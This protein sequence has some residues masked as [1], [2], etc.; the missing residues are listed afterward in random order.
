MNSQVCVRK[1]IWECH[2]PVPRDALCQRIVLKTSGGVCK[3]SLCSLGG[4]TP[5]RGGASPPGGAPGG[6]APPP[7]QEEGHLLEEMS[8]LLQE[9]MPLLQEMPVSS[10]RRGP[11]SKRWGPSSWRRGPSSKRRGPGGGCTLCISAPCAM[12]K[13]LVSSNRGPPGNGYGSDRPCIKCRASV[14]PTTMARGARVLPEGTLLEG[15]LQE[16]TLLL[17]AGQAKLSPK[18]EQNLANAASRNRTF[19]SGRPGGRN[20][21]S[22]RAGSCQVGTTRLFARTQTHTQQ[23]SHRA[24]MRKGKIPISSTD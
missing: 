13:H 6:G 12:R 22:G 9:M 18:L 21:R 11:S 7:L 14:G 24:V 3:V 17:E 2:H 20:A 8:P 16:G 5:P 19:Y 1:Q 15:T 4:G 10:T 23:R